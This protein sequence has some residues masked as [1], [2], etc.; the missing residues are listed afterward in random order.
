MTGIENQHA[1]DTQR[2]G[3]D[4]RR[5]I[6]RLEEGQFTLNMP[7]D[8]DLAPALENPPTDEELLPVLERAEAV[9]ATSPDLDFTYLRRLAF[10]VEFALHLRGRW[11]EPARN[12]AALALIHVGADAHG[13][14][15]RTEVSQKAVVISLAGWALNRPDPWLFEQYDTAEKITDLLEAAFYQPGVAAAHSRAAP[16]TGA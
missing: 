3:F 9:R 6:L 14:R 13:F 8:W 15:W 5:F 2:C 10:F 12:A 7:Y 16:G 11:P 1:V 4:L